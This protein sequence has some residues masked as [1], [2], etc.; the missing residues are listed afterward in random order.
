MEMSPDEQIEWARE[1]ANLV[2]AAG[3]KYVVLPME[4]AETLIRL[5]KHGQ[6]SCSFCMGECP[7]CGARGEG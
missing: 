2:A 3:H 7:E 4:I 1:T 5:A 6:G